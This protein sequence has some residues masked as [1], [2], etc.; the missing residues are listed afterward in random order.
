MGAEDPLD[1]VQAAAWHASVR[2]GDIDSLTKEV[3]KH[4]GQSTDH[5]SISLLI[6]CV[7]AW[8]VCVG[9]IVPLHVRRSR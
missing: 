4:I 2:A 6:N 1:A 7:C 5:H 9:F 8:D 3:T